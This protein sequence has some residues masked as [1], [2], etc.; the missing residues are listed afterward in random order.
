MTQENADATQ[1]TDT[2]LVVES[3]GAGQA[4]AK[5]AEITRLTDAL[6]LSEQQRKTEVGQRQVRMSGPDVMA[7]MDE[8]NLEVRALRR[9]IERQKWDNAVTDETT[10]SQKIGALDDDQR[11]DDAKTAMAKVSNTMGEKLSLAL[12]KAGFDE[13]HPKV[14]EFLKRWSE[15]NALEDYVE[16]VMDGNSFIVAEAE[17]VSNAALA[18]VTKKA[19]EGRR[20]GNLEDNTLGTGGQSGTPGANRSAEKPEFRADGSHVKALIEWE[21]NESAKRGT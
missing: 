1:T 3:E 11:A 5:D 17:K 8:N 4:D 14:Q 21:K 7:R 15:G 20:Q 9:D 19:D 10:R 2:T 16:I 13:D 12:E 6:A 18:A